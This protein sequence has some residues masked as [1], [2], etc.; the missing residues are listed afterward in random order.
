MILW[1]CED[2][3]LRTSVTPDGKFIY[4]IHKPSFRVANMRQEVFLQ[5]LG[6]DDED[7]P[8]ENTA[9]FPAGEVEE[10]QGEWIYEIPN[11]LPFRGV[12]YISKS[13]A[14]TRAADPLAIRL[15]EPVPTS[16]T[17][18]LK[19]ILHSKGLSGDS[20]NEAFADLPETVLL[21]LASISTDPEDL[22]RLA[23]LS[24]EFVYDQEGNLPIGLRY[25]VDTKGRHRPR[26]LLPDLFEVL[27]NNIALPDIY[28][29][30]MVLRPG[31]QGD[32]EIVG[33]WP[34]E[35]DSHVFEYLR[36]NSYIPWGHYASNMANDLVRYSISDLSD[37]DFAGLRHL[38]YQRT[39]IRLAEQLG[40]KLEAWNRC[41]TTSELEKLREKVVKEL[42]EGG[43]SSLKFDATLWGWNYG[44]DSAPSGYRLHASHQQIHQQFSMIPKEVAG[45]EMEN[46]IIPSYNCGDLVADFV[47]SYEKE[48][49]SSFFVDYIRA[50]RNNR[51]MDGKIDLI[52]DLVVYEDESV[53]LFVPKAQT[54][55]WELQLVTLDQVGN[56]LEADSNVRASLNRGIITA[57]RILTGMGAKLITVIEFPRRI[58]AKDIDQRL[59][60]SFLPKIPYSMGAFS[61]AQ[62][63]FINGHYPEDFAIACRAQLESQ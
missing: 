6:L 11:P 40:I 57:M 12:T 49:Q 15:P 22:K 17:G 58:G 20:L 16:M 27:V 54:S 25:E 61:E 14:D 36:R 1:L 52:A 23:E 62:L 31:A 48:Y 63:R 26:I 28:K 21:A 13:W 53:M 59:L 4:G 24:C 45:A 3:K 9:N 44:F 60:Y 43:T 32:S 8:I 51:R 18:F 30:V 19:K 39:Y 10:L 47:I 37:N 35:S 33:E 7:N 2:M 41:L 46:E 55:Q 56:V 42:A 34:E 50:V 38:Y 5:S 29:E